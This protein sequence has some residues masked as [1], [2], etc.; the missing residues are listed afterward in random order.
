MYLLIVTDASNLIS[1]CSQPLCPSF[2]FCIG[3]AT[4]QQ[5]HSLVVMLLCELREER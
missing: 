1:L 4:A 2:G 3:F 5:K